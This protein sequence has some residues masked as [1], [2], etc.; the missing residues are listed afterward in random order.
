MQRVLVSITETTIVTSV[1]N[2]DQYSRMK[3]IKQYGV[4]ADDP[5]SLATIF[6]LVIKLW[7][8]DGFVYSVFLC[9]DESSDRI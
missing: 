8:L 2:N 5:I 4:N 3:L 1:I 6:Y 7:T 9:F